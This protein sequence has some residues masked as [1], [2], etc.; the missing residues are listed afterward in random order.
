MKCLW[1]ENMFLNNSELGN[2]SYRVRIRILQLRYSVADNCQLMRLRLTSSCQSSRSLPW[3]SPRPAVPSPSGWTP[4][5][6][7][8]PT[9]ARTPGGRSTSASAAGC[10]RMASTAACSSSAPDRPQPRSWTRTRRTRWSR[11]CRW[12]RCCRRWCRWCRLSTARELVK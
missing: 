10:R 2:S 4:S 1:T 3:E 11:R 8:C 9:W 12:Q 6:S 7:P 5:S